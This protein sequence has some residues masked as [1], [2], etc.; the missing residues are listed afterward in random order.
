[1]AELALDAAS[2]LARWQLVEQNESG[3]IIQLHFV[4]ATPLW[5]FKDDI[6]VRIA[7]AAGGG[8]LLTAESRSRVGKG[9]LGQNPR[10]LRELLGA[11]RAAERP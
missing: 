4:R 3:G 11:I 7:P 10:N 8:S 5:R 6:R 2:G 1:M 9:D